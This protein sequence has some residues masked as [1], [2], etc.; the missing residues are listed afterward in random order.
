MIHRITT[1]Y[2]ITQL[3]TKDGYANGKYEWV[4]I[5]HGTKTHISGFFSNGLLMDGTWFE[6]YPGGQ[7]KEGG[8]YKN[9]VRVGIWTWY[10]PEGEIEFQG[11]TEDGYV[12]ID[13][14]DAIEVKE[15]RN[16]KGNR[17]RLPLQYSRPRGL[18]H[19]KA[20]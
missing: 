3:R 9:G 17:F 10:T 1:P 16:K 12:F 8:E 20:D 5:S 2:G 4:F 11:I 14:N 18:R 19:S 7:V 13:V 6:Y 15:K